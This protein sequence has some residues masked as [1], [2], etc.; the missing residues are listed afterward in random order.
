MRK[1]FYCFIFLIFGV[2][3]VWSENEVRILFSGSTLGRSLKFIDDDGGDQA[4][5]AARKTLIDKIK[6]NSGN[7]V[8]LVDTGNIV[9]EYYVSVLTNG[10]ADYTAMNMIGYDV[11]GIGINEI[12]RSLADYNI[13]Y[14]KASFSMVNCNVKT[15]KGKRIANPY[16]IKTI[17]GVKVG[18][19]SVLSENAYL[20]LSNEVKTEITV[21]NPIVIMEKVL[22]QMKEKEKVDVIVALTNVDY[23]SDLKS[24][25]GF[26]ASLF[27]SI[28]LIIEGSYGLN[29][30]NVFKVNGTRVYTIEKNGMYLGDVT[31]ELAKKGTGGARNQLNIVSEK[32]HPINVHVGGKLTSEQIPEDK[33]LLQRLEKI[34]KKV[35]SKLSSIEG[36]SVIATEF[37]SIGKMDNF[38]KLC[39][40][41]TDALRVGTGSDV[42]FLNAGLFKEVDLSKKYKLEYTFASG[43]LKYDNNAVIVSLRGDEL[44]NIVEY[45][46]IRRGFGQFLIFS[47]MTVEY[48]DK[49]KKVTDL[50]IYQ[51]KVVD[52]KIYKVAISDWLANGGDTYY[53]FEREKNKIFTYIPIKNLINNYVADM[54]NVLNDTIDMRRLKIIE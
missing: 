46:M 5:Y 54:D 33:K 34:T 24:G 27:P 36:A 30:N 3:S 15:L 51:K 8:V 45:S 50:R 4:G 22:A 29:E 39:C 14:K 38:T 1:Y 2:L 16:F 26:L 28:D 19:I 44:K 12:N 18:F 21:E 47:G 6:K 31:F 52:D 13:L 41:A 43:L 11:A 32:F 17:N 20:A 48:S 25:A 23:H 7:N 42:A 10:E 35:D 53:F 9:S 40:I 49:D 37:S